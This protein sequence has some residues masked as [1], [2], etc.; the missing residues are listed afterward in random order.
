MGEACHIGKDEL[1]ALDI[2][3]IDIVAVDDQA[4]TNPDEL[5][6][7]RAKL[8]TYHTLHLSELERQHPRLVVSLNEVAVVP[9]RRDKHNPLGSDAHQVGGG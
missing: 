8:F 9:V 7:F 1:L 6:A 4:P 2:D 5:E 3:V